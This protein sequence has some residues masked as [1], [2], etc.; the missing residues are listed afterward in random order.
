MYQEWKIQL[1]QTGVKLEKGKTYKL[2]FKAKSTLDRTIQYA[3]QRD[4]A[5]HKNADGGEDWTPYT[6]ETVS[7]TVDYKTFE[8][9]FKMTFDSDE[10]T[11]FNISMGGKNITDKHVISID[12]IKLVEIPES[13]MPKVEA[14]KIDNDITPAS[15]ITLSDFSIVEVTE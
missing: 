10:G 8:K 5:V 13:E 11:I 4:G 1:K 7:V 15:T 3:L 6:Q 9:K 2:S 14:G 12:D